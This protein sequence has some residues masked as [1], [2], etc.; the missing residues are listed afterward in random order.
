MPIAGTNHTSFTVS[1]LMRSMAF[2]RE[3]IGLE[4]I[5]LEPR[6]PALIEQVVGVP[7][8]EV[9]VAYLS[10]HG[11]TIELI[12]YQAPAEREHVRPRPCDTGFAHVAYDVTDLDAILDA[13]AAHGVEPINPPSEVD[14]GPNAGLRVVYTRDP[15]GVAIEFIERPTN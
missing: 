5:S 4:L 1:E 14:K 13:A 8:A 15:D 3:V 11:H 12:E 7:G 2:W 9:M 6:D 10:G